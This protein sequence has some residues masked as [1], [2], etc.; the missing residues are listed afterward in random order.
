MLS[1]GF[2]LVTDKPSELVEW[3]TVELAVELYASSLLNSDLGEVFESKYRI[4]RVHNLLRYT[5]VHVSRKPSFPTGQTLKLP[6]SRFGAFGLQLFAKIGI[7]STPIFDLLGVEKPVIRADCNIHYSAIYSKDAKVH[8]L[9]RIAVLQGYMQ[10]EHFASPVIR[11]RRRLDNPAKIVPVMRWYMESCLDSSVGTGNCRYAMHKVDCD[12]S[13]IV[14]HCRERLSFWKRFAFNCLESFTSTISC[15]L[16][17]R[18]WQI[19]DILTDK[20]VSCIMIIDF[21]PRPILV[22]PFSGYRERFGV[23]LHCIE[24]GLTILVRQFKLECDSSKHIIYE[25]E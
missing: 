9:L 2:C 4:F 22:S 16:H 5:M 23:S 3:P 24:K 17:Q 10:I 6:F 14:S 25:C 20:L 1:K 12:Y 15:S 18:R 11:N 13:L 21:I 19:G 8:N 7:T